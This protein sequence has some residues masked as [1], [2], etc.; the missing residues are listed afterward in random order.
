MSVSGQDEIDLFLETEGTR[1]WCLVSI[2]EDGFGYF[3]DLVSAAEFF[4]LSETQLRDMLEHHLN[5]GIK[6]FDISKDNT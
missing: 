3:G 6:F 2:K 5:P 1:D 4:G